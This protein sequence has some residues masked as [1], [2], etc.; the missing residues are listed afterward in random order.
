MSNQNKIIWVEILRRK[1]SFLYCFFTVE[2]Q[3]SKY[4]KKSLGIDFAYDNY[5]YIKNR[6]IMDARRLGQLEGILRE[7]LKKNPDYFSE[8]AKKCYIQCDQ[9]LKMAKK[10]SGIKPDKLM[11]AELKKLYQDYVEQNLRLIPFLNPLFV[12]EKIMTEIL[13]K[14]LKD[15]FKFGAIEEIVI[16]IKDNFVAQEIRDILKITVEIQKNQKLET[17]VLR[18][19]V[20]KAKSTLLKHKKISLMI[21]RHI[22]KYGW[23]P[24]MSYIGEL[25]SFGSVLDRLKTLIKE[26][27]KKKLENTR[28]RKKNDEEKLKKLIKK[29]GISG[30][31]LKLIK[32]VRQFLHLRFYRIDVFFVAHY[33][34]IPFYREM[35]KR[36]GISYGEILYLNYKEILEGLDKG[37]IINKKEIKR[38]QQQYAFVLVNGRLKVYSGKAVDSLLKEDEIQKEVSAEIKTLKGM[39]ACRGMARGVVR[40]ILDISDM[41]KLQSG[42]ILVTNMTTPDLM[43][44]IERAG[45]IVTDEGGILCHA[46]VVSRELGTPCI[47]GTQIATK[48]L[49]DG[50]LVEVDAEK[51]IVRKIEK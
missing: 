7:K 40:I 10:I 38:R 50:D 4:M 11:N 32:V 3:L 34:M 18:G 25:M 28:L 45:G 49:K 21:N 2:G 23:L 27:C 8:F 5:K 39:V 51:G 47:T 44:A 1:S 13:Q 9:L 19:P 12:L 30:D 16:P 37:L 33:Q 36:L 15:R 31:L 35:A 22:K 14:E 20:V 42:N 26:D 17:V 48:V 24:T 41:I 6:V 43:P 29:F 46:A